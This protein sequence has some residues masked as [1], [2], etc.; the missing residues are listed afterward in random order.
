MFKHILGALTILIL[1]A[2]TQAQVIVPPSLGP[3]DMYRLVFVTSTEGTSMSTNLTS[4]DSIV[5]AAAAQNPALDGIT[6]Q[7]IG[8]T[9]NVN[10]IDHTNT[11]PTAAAQVPIFRLDGANVADDYADLWDESI[12]SSIVSM[13]LD[14]HK[15]LKF[16]RELHPMALT[17]T[18]RLDSVHFRFPVRDMDSVDPPQSVGLS[19]V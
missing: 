10:A 3:G 19:T 8:S 13:N 6:W 9:D 14:S 18:A 15:A 17:T 2:S 11:S 12:N 16:G 4:Y 7:V 5:Q 1:S